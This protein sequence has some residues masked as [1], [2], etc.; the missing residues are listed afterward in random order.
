MTTRGYIESNGYRLHY[1][2][3]GEGTPAL[4]IGS[5]VY[6][7]RTFSTNLR[8]KLK[9]AFIDHRGFAEGENSPDTSRYELPVLLDDM[10]LMRQKLQLGKVVV[11][12]HSGHAFLALEYAKKF[13]QHVSH[14]VLIAGAPQFSEAFSKE[15][16]RY[17]E[18]TVA[19]ERKAE[20]E[21][22]LAQLGAE[23]AAAPEKRFIT[24]CLRLGAR[25]WYNPTY[26]ATTLWA[27]VRVNM[28]I[29]DHMWG[30]IFR[31]IDITKGLE[32][33][34]KP[35]FLALGLFD[36][37]VPPHFTW[38]PYRARFKNLTFRLFE[39]S[40]HTPQL[41]EAELFD[42]ELLKWLESNA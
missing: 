41:E 2:V 21:K 12:G 22:N 24:F 28:H 38:N 35:V 17:F 11:I 7:P 3:E 40:G 10:E 19:P 27:G 6:Y 36:Y 20:L 8:R 29:I 4:V 31:D 9:M 39:K 5:A 16:D 14:V 42:R 30:R 32:S 25:S 18:D 26:D 34:D 37:L 33:F 13:P 15:A 23:I 1:S